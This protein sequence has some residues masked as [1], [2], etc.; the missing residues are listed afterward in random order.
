[1]VVVHAQSNVFLKIRASRV[2]IHPGRHGVSMLMALIKF[3]SMQQT[4]KENQLWK[5]TDLVHVR[6]NVFQIHVFRMAIQQGHQC[7]KI[8]MALHKN[9]LTQGRLSKTISRQVN[10]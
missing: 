8:P 4:V 1:M 2:V 9:V 10:M 5:Q 6:F 3:V 7:V